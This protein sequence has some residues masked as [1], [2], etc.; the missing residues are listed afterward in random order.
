MPVPIQYLP[1]HAKPVKNI[2]FATPADAQRVAESL[3]AQGVP[4]AAISIMEVPYNI[5]GAPNTNNDGSLS[6]MILFA[7]DQEITNEVGRKQVVS[8]PYTEPAGQLVF[9]LDSYPNG[10]WQFLVESD[11]T[12][13]VER[14]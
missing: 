10:Q 5:G 7:K 14:R 6:L 9:L 8:V 11:R 13:D 2:N 1:T 3:V 12:G 4:E